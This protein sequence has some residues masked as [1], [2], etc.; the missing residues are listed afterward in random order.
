M[1]I[2]KIPTRIMIFGTFDGIHKGH[3]NFFKQAKKI[4]KS[5]S[6]SFLIASIARDK[7]VF[8]I[9][10]EFPTLSERKRMSLVKK[11]KIIDKVVLSGLRNYLPHVIK[12]R[13]D[14][15]ALGYDQKAYVKNLRKDLRNKGKSVT[16]IKVVRLKPYKENIYK[17]KLLKSRK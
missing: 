9:K 3:I 8:K 11:Y 6:K 13:P 15:I 14:V 4:A 7:N 1:K 12:E 16:S 17:N 10:G 5:P 2:K